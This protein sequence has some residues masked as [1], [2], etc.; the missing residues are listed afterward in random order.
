MADSANG[1]RRAPPPRW[2]FLISLLALILDQWTK[3]WFVDHYTLY[4]SRPVIE[5]V[6]SF[7]RTYNTGAAFSLFQD[8]PEWLTLF[9]IVV[10]GLMVVFRDH[11]FTRHPL[12]QTAF[13]LI[14]GGVVGNLI[15]RMRYGHVVD[16]LHWHGGFE[17]PIFNLADSFICTGVGLY[18]LAGFL[19]RKPVAA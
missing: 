13:G 7:T 8:H 18:L 3:R 12:E 1:G 17:W 4:E 10:F 19:N 15:D 16:F 11:I 5:D 9:S 6:F 2:P 14:A